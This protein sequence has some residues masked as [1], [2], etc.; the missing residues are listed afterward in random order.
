MLE[1][2]AMN[3]IEK[4]QLRT[5]LED[6]VVSGVVKSI[7]LVLETIVEDDYEQGRVGEETEAMER[8]LNKMR[9]KVGI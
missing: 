1:I 6:A 7:L 4:E 5:M 8:V 3:E 2:Y 9:E